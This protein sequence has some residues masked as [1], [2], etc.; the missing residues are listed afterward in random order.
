MI[1]QLR[2]HNFKIWKDTGNITFSS[3]KILCQDS[4]FREM[5]GKCRVCGGKYCCCNSGC[6]KPKDQLGIQATRQTI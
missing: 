1:R 6:E 4:H 5:T 2:I 3:L